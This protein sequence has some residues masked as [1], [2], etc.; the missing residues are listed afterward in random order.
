MMP[1]K[2]LLDN[3]LTPQETEEIRDRTLL[4][5]K[6]PDLKEFFHDNNGN[7]SYDQ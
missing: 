6:W 5:S 7:I 3:P 1:C 2:I 4:Q